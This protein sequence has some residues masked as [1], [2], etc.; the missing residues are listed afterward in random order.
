MAGC[1][2]IVV[3][4]ITFLFA[5]IIAGELGLE[6]NAYFVVAFIITAGVFGIAFASIKAKK[7]RE[8]EEKS[9]TT[10]LLKQH[11]ESANDFTPTH[12]FITKDGSGFIQAEEN[13]LKI[14]IGG[15]ASKVSTLTSRIYH[16]DKILSVQ[17]SENG[18]SILG[19]DLGN[20][21]GMA[22]IGGLV[23]GGAGAVVGAIAGQNAKKVSD[24]SIVL[25][26]D[27]L[28]TPFVSL[29]FMTQEVSRGSQ[30]HMEALSEANKWMGIINILISRRN[31]NNLT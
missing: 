14:K 16:I 18:R 7:K 11:R 30:E 20:T 12:Q 19:S 25:S 6:G 22:V 17:I 5:S 10:E 8:E 2:L 29:N 23:F 31:K 1:L 15:K 26:L 24:V 4:V 28:T 9:K 3:T 21:I 13:R 27:D